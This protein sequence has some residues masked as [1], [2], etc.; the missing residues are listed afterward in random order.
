LIAQQAAHFLPA[1]FFLIQIFLFEKIG[2]D[3]SSSWF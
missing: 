2:D 3:Q 1:R